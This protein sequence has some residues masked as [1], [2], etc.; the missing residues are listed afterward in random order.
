MDSMQRKTV[1]ILALAMAL[2]TALIAVI[3]DEDLRE[4]LGNSYW[5]IA[6]VIIACVLIVLSGYAF[7]LTLQKRLKSLNATAHSLPLEASN[8]AAPDHDEIIGLAR[9]IER[10][11]QTLQKVEAS[12]RG[13]VEDQADLICRYGTGGA[14]SF[15]NGAYERAFGRKRVEL[16]GQPFSFFSPAESAGADP[17]TFEREI[18]MPD[19]QKRWVT[20]TQRAIRDNDGNLLEYQGVGHDVTAR[21]EAE[22]ALLRAK[23]AAEAADRA[24]S[25]FLAVVSHEIRTPINGVIGFAK[26]LDE[27]TLT[28]DQREQVAMIHTSGL[29]LEKLIS[30]ILDLSKIEAGKIEIEHTPFGFHREVEEACAFFQQQARAAG[31]TLDVKIDPGVPVIINGDAARLRQV[32]TNL[33]GNAF[34]FTERGGVEVHVS[35]VKGDSLPDGVN[36]NIRLLF[37]VSDTGIGIPANKIN[38]L[39]KPFS[40]VD[41]SSRRRRGG[42]GLGLAISKRLCGLMGG[43]IRVESRL[44]EGSTFHFSVLANYDKRDSSLP[45]NSKLSTSS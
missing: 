29:A 9:N 22:A 10:M 35:C 20:W 41:S 36:R 38:E 5:L 44:N 28:R 11:A 25:E 40:Q 30:D 37:T 24:K 42:T 31:L 34:K 23:E 18:G 2:V 1:F 43:G 33:I 27:T 4:R 45:F 19:G 21:K 26:M 13:I 14:L 12:Y 15:V 6:M 7:D 3:M 39:F 17:Y 32:L 8:G 16:I